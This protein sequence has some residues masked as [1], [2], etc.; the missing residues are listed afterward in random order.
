MC[1]HIYIYT[2]IYIYI[3]TYIHTHIGP[4]R[5]PRRHDAGG[6]L[7]HARARRR[8]RALRGWRNAREI[9]SAV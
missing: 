3:Y 2:Y 6:R 4:L 5:R 1:I 7:A 9:V 8:S